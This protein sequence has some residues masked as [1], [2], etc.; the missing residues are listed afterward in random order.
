MTINILNEIKARPMK[1]AKVVTPD[2]VPAMRYC[3]S[4]I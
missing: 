2:N 4:A 1:E 3:H